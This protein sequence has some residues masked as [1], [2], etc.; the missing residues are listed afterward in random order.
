MDIVRIERKL[1][2]AISLMACTDGPLQERLGQAFVLTFR[3]SRICF[4]PPT[5]L[6]ARPG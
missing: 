4:T 5:A 6:P 2:D 1:Y 3:T